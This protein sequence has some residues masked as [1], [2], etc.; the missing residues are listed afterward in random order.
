[1]QNLIDKIKKKKIHV[2]VI[3]LGYV[4]LP[5]SILLAKKKFKVFGFDV[6][7]SKIKKLKKNQSYLNRIDSSVIKKNQKKFYFTSNFSN[8]KNCDVIIIC[9][10]T[11][12]NK[13]L[14]PDLKYLKKTLSQIKNSLRNNQI[15]ILESTSYPGTTEEIFLNEFKK[16]FI[17]G[18]NFYLGFSSERINPGENE[19]KINLIPKVVSG[20]SK[21]CLKVISEFYGLVF[22]NLVKAKNIKTAEFSKLLENIY[23]AVNIAFINEMK[24]VASKMNLDIYDIINL[25]NTK[26]FGF[27]KFNPG[28]GVGGHCIPIDPEYLSWKS[29]KLGYEPKFIKLSSRVNL[30]VINYIYKNIKKFLK[31][32]RKDYNKCKILILGL[33]YKKNVDDLRESSSLKLINILK[34]NN[35]KNLYFNDPFFTGK[36]N[37]R[38]YNFNLKKIKITENKLRSYDL[39]VLMTD[40]DAFDYKKIYKFSKKILDCRGRYPVDHKVIR[41]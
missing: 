31:N 1:M 3:G 15:V 29:K 34:S 8:I 11:P 22:K 13:K 39:V 23:R 38:N 37:T 10:P 19:D 16:K 26:P 6:D 14:K 7:K 30:E 24:I 17:I 25:A 35:F 21:N 5:L 9:V 28:P 27:Q 32:I 12:L 40:H 33:S 20:V 18:K 41:G 2:G 4:G 36:I